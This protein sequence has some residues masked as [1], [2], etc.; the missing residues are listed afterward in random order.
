[1]DAWWKTDMVQEENEG[2]LS[3]ERAAEVN[4]V[5]LWPKEDPSGYGKERE[6]WVAGFQMTI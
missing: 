1:V 5:L 4:E 2:P 3:R 6:K